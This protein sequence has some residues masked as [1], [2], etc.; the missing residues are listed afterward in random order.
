MLIDSDWHIH[1]ECSYDASN[2]PRRIAK[3]AQEQGLLK[4]GITD[5]LNYNDEKFIADV[6][7]SAECAKEL[8]GQ[9]P[10][11]VLGV[12]LT[13]IAL[14][15]FEHIHSQIKTVIPIERIEMM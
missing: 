6:R 9:Y 14:P 8:Q 4:I 13:P 12:E 5:H 3:A 1:S 11:V 2:P 7:R 10:F 15:E